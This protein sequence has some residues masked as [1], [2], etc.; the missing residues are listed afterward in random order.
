MKTTFPRMSFWIVTLAVIGACATAR[1]ESDDAEALVRNALNALPQNTFVAKLKLTTDRQERRDLEL[2]HKVVDG[3]RSSYL[4]V[5]SPAD[6][7]GVRFLFLQRFD[8]PP[9]QYLRV[10]TSPRHL[11]VTDDVRMRSF[12]NSTF[13]VADFVEPALDEFDYAFVGEEELLGRKCK[14]VESIP[15]DPSKA[16][17]GKTV[18]AIDPKDLLI[19]KRDFYEH[20]G[21][22]F[23]R[24]TA[25]TVEQVSGHWTQKKQTMSSLADNVESHL[26]ILEIQYDV[27][28]DD[29]IFKPDY[30]LH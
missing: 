10:P 17:Y 28:L 24:W 21:K 26:E 9:V 1:A 12:L 29:A 15:K 3:M 18:V 30:L 5:T 7:A 25:D 8:K 22:L 2:R 27:E 13:Y 20:D 4:E 16:I 19:L 6:V 23:K 11:L 14:L